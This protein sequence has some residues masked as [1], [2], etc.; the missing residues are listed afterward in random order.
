MTRYEVVA[1]C[2]DKNN[3]ELVLTYLLTVGETLAF[4][5]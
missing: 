1:V 5:I 4:L 2:S 3:P